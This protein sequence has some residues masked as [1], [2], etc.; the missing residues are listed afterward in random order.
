MS[1]QAIIDDLTR[2]K[3]GVVKRAPSWD[4]LQ[5]NLKDAE[6][7]C[8][9]QVSTLCKKLGGSLYLANSLVLEADSGYVFSDT[10]INGIPA[11]L[12]MGDL[13]GPVMHGFAW[14]QAIF[15][16]KYGRGASPY[17]LVQSKFVVA[18]A[19]SHFYEMSLPSRGALIIGQEFDRLIQIIGAEKSDLSK[20]DA[21][22]AI[23]AMLLAPVLFPPSAIPS[24]ADIEI[25]LEWH[26]WQY[27]MVE[28]CES[29][30]IDSMK[31]KYLEDPPHTDLAVLF[32]RLGALVMAA[33]KAKV[34]LTGLAAMNDLQALRK[35]MEQGAVTA[36]TFRAGLPAIDLPIGAHFPP[37]VA[38]YLRAHGFDEL[39]KIYLSAQRM[40][41]SLA[42]L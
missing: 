5:K 35:G 39:Q 12:F 29:I 15:Q 20:P 26:A 6:A 34:P 30:Y 21:D 41:F 25:Q 3:W 13:T 42:N 24:A 16:A 1:N 27:R 17:N 4:P 10:Q 37:L 31:A 2:V 36:N 28:I 8:L 23:S 18:G 38:A 7:D 9:T 14:F 22:K 33:Y 32:D 19:P 11:G 40:T